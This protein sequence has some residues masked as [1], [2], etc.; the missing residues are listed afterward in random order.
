MQNHAFSEKQ[1]TN[2]TNNAYCVTSRKG[3]GALWSASGFVR[4]STVMAIVALCALLWCGMN[5]AP[6]Y[7]KSY[8]MPKVTIDAV[9]DPNGDL[10]VTEQRM[11]SFHGNYTAVWWNYNNLPSGATLDLNS[12]RMA[13]TDSQGNL[14][15]G[16]KPLSSV[17]FQLKWREA[18]GPG[19]TAYSFDEPKDTVYAFFNETDSSIMMEIDYTVEDAVQ[20][21]SDVGELYWQFVGS[22]WAA[23]SDNVTMTVSL[24]TPAGAPIIPGDTVRAWGH[25]SLNSTV[26]INTDGTVTYQVP[27][28]KA[29][30]YAEARVLFPTDWLVGVA[31]QD[32]NAHPSTAHLDQALNEEHVWADRANAQRATTIGLFIAV[33]VL[34][35]ATLIWGI[36]SFFRYSKELKPTFTEQYWRDVPVKGE[37]PA[38]IGRLIRFDAESTNDFTA[39]IMHLANAGALRIDRAVREND[40]VHTAAAAGEKRTLFGKTKTHTDYR[41]TRVP[42][43][44]INLNSELDREAMSFLFDVVAQGNDT[45][46]FGDISTFAKQNGVQFNEGLQRWQ[47]M[48]TSHV[49]AGEYFESYSQSRRFRMATIA[50]LLMAVVA[51]LA[52]LFG[53]WLVVIPAVIVGV[54]LIIVSR[55][56]DRRTQKGADAYARCMALKKWLTEF[57]TLNERPPLDIKVW[58][59]FMVYALLLGVAEETLKQLRIAE[60]ELFDPDLV[61]S[62]PTVPWWMWYSASL[63][64]TGIPMVTDAFAQSIDQALTNT[65]AAF[66]PNVGEVSASGVGGGFSVGGGGGFGGGGGAR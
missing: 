20:A 2:L 27:K 22:Q 53:N 62:M 52:L 42:E 19:T 16:W 66:S 26:H 11:F 41:L 17:P 31:P 45:L 63:H 37:H 10:H 48:V 33:L 24:P 65:D 29:G 61:A 15:E 60:P 44:E 32:P 58:G 23:D 9:I 57:S 47:G 7:A 3:E 55:F 49:I 59:E 43:V 21:Y 4:L 40:E 56:M 13:K 35:T 38:V 54:A 30:T 39:T 34:C 50:V 8:D 28:V 6:A 1:D 5:P 46:W 64:A 14:Q 18:G 25:G 51:L 36:R 12:V